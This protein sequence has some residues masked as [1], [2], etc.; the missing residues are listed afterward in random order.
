MLFQGLLKTEDVA[1]AFSPAWT[2]LD[3]PQGSFHRD[4]RQENCGGLTPLGKTDGCW[5]LLGV[6]GFLCWSE[7]TGL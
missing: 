2:Q 7:P 4:E 1:L 6:R 3:S 5:F